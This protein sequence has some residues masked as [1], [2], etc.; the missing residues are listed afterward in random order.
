MPEDP[1]NPDETTC[2]QEIQV[3]ID[4]ADQAED[5]AGQIVFED[6]ID[7]NPTQLE[8]EADYGGDKANGNF[9]SGLCVGFGISCIATFV[10]LWFVIFFTPFVPSAMTYENLL[11]VFIYPLIYLL[12]IGLVAVTAGIVRQYYSMKK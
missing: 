5:D 11:A 1:P 3:P 10:I 6:R 9:V 2:Q 12:A 4:N 8:T 7:Q